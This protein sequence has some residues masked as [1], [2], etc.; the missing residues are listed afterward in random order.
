MIVIGKKLQTN[1]VS[2]ALFPGFGGEGG[3]GPGIFLA[4]AGH[5]TA[6]HLEFVVY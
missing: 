6:K 1:L 5:M 3:K 4:S 2:R